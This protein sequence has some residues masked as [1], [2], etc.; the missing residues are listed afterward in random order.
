VSK[1][2]FQDS[3]PALHTYLGASAS[4]RSSSH[5]PIPSNSEVN[6]ICDAK[7]ADLAT[8]LPPP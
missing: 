2:E 4:A 6:A 3:S 7:L 8:D 5:A 1:E